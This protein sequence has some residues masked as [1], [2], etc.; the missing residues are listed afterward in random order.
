MTDPDKKN[1][2]TDKTNG[3][4]CEAPSEITK[5]PDPHIPYLSHEEYVQLSKYKHYAT[6]TWYE[7]FMLNNVTYVV[8]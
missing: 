3:R 2:A 4:H 6:K 1:E 8:E 7:M 5:K